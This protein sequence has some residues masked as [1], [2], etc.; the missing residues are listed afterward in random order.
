M[1]EMFQYPTIH[2]LAEFLSKRQSETPASEASAT[3]AACR[4]ARSDLMDRQRALRRKHRAM[5]EQ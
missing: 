2:S 5:N 3:R 4:A 1:V